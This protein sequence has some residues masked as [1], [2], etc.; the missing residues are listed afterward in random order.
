VADD[1]AVVWDRAGLQALSYKRCVSLLETT[2]IYKPYFPLFFHLE[3]RRIFP[4]FQN[5]I[6]ILEIVIFPIFH[7]VFCVITLLETL[8][9]VKVLL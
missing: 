3:E 7:F 4:I 5:Y 9:L 6:L 2:S 8:L 1:D